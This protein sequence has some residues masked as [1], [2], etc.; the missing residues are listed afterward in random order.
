MIQ[1]DRNRFELRKTFVGTHKP[2]IE[3]KAN[4]SE[5]RAAGVVLSHDCELDKVTTS[6]TVL[7]G[8]VRLPDKIQEGIRENAHLRALYVP[9]S[10]RLT[11]ALLDGTDADETV[12]TGEELEAYI[13]FRRVTTIVRPPVNELTLAASMNEDR[14]MLLQ[15]Q[16]F[17]FFSRRVLPSAWSEWEV[18]DETDWE[19]DSE[20]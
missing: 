11:A 10:P 9:P 14:K 19:V 6:A 3:H 8:L 12:G 13:D 20:G 4:A 17:R 2:N 18:E 1:V 7:V 5:V 16:L 15:A